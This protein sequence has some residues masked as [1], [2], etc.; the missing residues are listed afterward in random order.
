MVLII[1][2][3]DSFTYNVFQQIASLGFTVVVKQHDKI[4]VE[5]I[6]EIDPSHI[7]ISAGPKR[8]ADSGISME[9]IRCYYKRVPIL[10]ICLGH[11]CI[12]EVFGASV[13]EAPVILHGKTD[14]IQHNSQ[15]IFKGVPNPLIATR[16]N[17]LV[18]DNV[19]A[20][21]ELT[22]KSE[23]RSI[24]AVQHTEYPL[25]GVQFHPESFMTEHGNILM[26]NFLEC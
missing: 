19:P 12:G 9:V 16:Y 26:R 17:S 21:L 15:G 6:D 3:Y 18:L 14:A 24:Q 11:Q 2:N 7:I 5:Q 25:Y 22:A 8:P 20:G 23:D 4:T 13:I 1:D 10:G